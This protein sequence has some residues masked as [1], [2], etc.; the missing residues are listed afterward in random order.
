MSKNVENHL[1]YSGDKDKADYCKDKTPASS[2]EDK[3]YCADF[4]S[5]RDANLKKP[6]PSAKA[7]PESVQVEWKDLKPSCP[8]KQWPE[9]GVRATAKL[10]DGTEKFIDMVI[11]FDGKPDDPKSGDLGSPALVRLH[12]NGGGKDDCNIVT[13]KNKDI[14][15]VAN[16]DKPDA[17]IA[18]NDKDVIKNWDVDKATKNKAFIDAMRDELTPIDGW[19]ANCNGDAQK[20]LEAAAKQA[21]TDI[22]G[23]ITVPPSVPGAGAIPST[24]R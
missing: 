22:A 7:S 1:K 2:F 15:Q 13:Y 21:G 6:P 12:V 10:P 16:C 8:T 19:I 23:G 3:N 9:L 17:V 14:W 5:W 18:T 24:N 11:K 20:K 4:W